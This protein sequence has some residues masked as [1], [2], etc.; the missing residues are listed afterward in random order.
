MTAGSIIIPFLDIELAALNAVR[1]QL[2]YHRFEIGVGTGRFAEALKIDYGIDPAISPLQ[3]AGTRSILGINAIGEN[4]P[5]RF[6]CMGTAFILFTLC[7][8][9]DP[10]R[11]LQ[12]CS[13]ILMPDGRLVIGLIPRLSIWGHLLAQ[14]KKENNPFYR[15][16]RLRNI[17][18]T[19]EMLS[20]SGFSVIESWSTLMQSPDNSLEVEPPRQG[21]D[22]LAGFCVL[23]ASNKDYP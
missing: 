14:K 21:I 2:P 12:E 1:E 17:A 9:A 10:A 13:R 20:G 15:H 18:E 5:V 8:L 6:E 19:V 4:L 23:V 11:V 3:L 22:D 7:F 16:A